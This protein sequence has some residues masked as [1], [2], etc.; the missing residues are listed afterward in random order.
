MRSLPPAGRRFSNAKNLS[1]TD[2]PWQPDTGRWP[3]RIDERLIAA[4]S[5][6]MNLFAKPLQQ[7]A[8]DADCDPRLPCRRLQDRPAFSTSKVVPRFHG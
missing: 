4:A 6:A 2:A 3:G 8:I 7:I 1:A 5:G